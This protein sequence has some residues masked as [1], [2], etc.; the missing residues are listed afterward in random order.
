M[1]T[2]LSDRN[3]KTA[4]HIL[5]AAAHALLSRPG[6]VHYTMGG[7]R[8][9]GIA[10]RKTIHDGHLFPFRGDCSSTTTWMLWLA[11]HHSFNL[12]DVVNGANWRAGYTGTQVAHGT[13]V[14]AFKGGRIG[15]LIFY[16]GT[17]RVPEHVAMKIAPGHVFS[18]GSEGGP[19]LLPV[20][21]RS[22]VHDVARR[23]FH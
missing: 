5:V 22:D 10:H 12:R 15:D 14:S 9:D 19:Y 4:R 17:S 1:S 11:L 3:T 23:Y 16:G 18:H 20:A 7:D 6:D 8:W 21:Y 13:G 2:N